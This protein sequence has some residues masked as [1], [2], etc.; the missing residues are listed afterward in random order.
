MVDLSVQ[1]E[2][3]RNDD[4]LSVFERMLESVVVFGVAG[5]DG[6]RVDVRDVSGNAY[7]CGYKYDEPH[8]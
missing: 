3:T 5:C 4:E 1:H 6:G 7:G 8:D 2:R